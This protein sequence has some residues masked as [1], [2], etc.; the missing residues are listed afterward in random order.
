MD[1]LAMPTINRDIKHDL[2]VVKGR[3]LVLVVVSVLGLAS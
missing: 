1:A 2:L 3:R